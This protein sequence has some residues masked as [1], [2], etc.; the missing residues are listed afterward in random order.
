MTRPLCIACHWEKKNNCLPHLPNA[1]LVSRFLIWFHW[2]LLVASAL[3][4]WVWDQENRAV[5]GL[6][7]STVPYC[8]SLESNCFYGRALCFAKLNSTT[9]CNCFLLQSIMSTTCRLCDI[10]LDS[11]RKEHKSSR[12]KK[13]STSILNA[14]LIKLL[15]FHQVAPWSM[16]NSSGVFANTNSAY[17]DCI[18]IFLSF[19]LGPKATE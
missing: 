7:L 18:V 13:I 5:A 17:A 9:G 6:S 3:L 2:H 15:H 19:N 11:F 10:S 16:N 4:S 1:F 12:G 14:I 8:P